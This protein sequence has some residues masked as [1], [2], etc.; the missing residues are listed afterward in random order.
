MQL[1]LNADAKVKVT[2][3][4]KPAITA[5][6]VDRIGTAS[7][8]LSAEINPDLEESE[9]HFEYTDDADFQA[10]G[11]ANATVT[12]VP[13]ADLGSGDSEILVSQ[14]IKGL[15][16]FTTYYY[17]VVA[18][19]IAGTTESE[20]VSFTTF[21]VAEPSGPCANDSLRNG[22]SAALSDCRAYEQASPVDKNGGDVTGTVT[23]AKSSVEG[24]RVL[25]EAYSA[26][27]GGEGAQEFDPPYLATRGAGGWSSRACCRR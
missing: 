15:S 6:T 21:I 2:F 24:D 5:L 16:P 8:R 14:E 23:S 1:V 19:N 17:R 27:P 10:N 3:S 7:A 22:A 11:F 20:P 9:Y 12:P 18:S 25:F 4:A 26:L 13:D